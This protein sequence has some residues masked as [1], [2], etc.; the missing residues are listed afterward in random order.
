MKILVTG[1]TGLLGGRLISKLI[2][3]CHQIV[4]LTRSKSSHGKLKA[5]GAT[6]VDGDLE[7]CPLP[8]SFRCLSVIRIHRRGGLLLYRNSDGF[9]KS[10]T[11]NGSR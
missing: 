6:P 8:N 10:L 4:A 3:D 5:M 11:R 9:W 7:S 1:G 2:E